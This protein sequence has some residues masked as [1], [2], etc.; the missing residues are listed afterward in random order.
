MGGLE[1][2]DAVIGRYEPGRRWEDKERI[3]EIYAIFRKG[4]L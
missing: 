3:E 4:F 1:D 2:L